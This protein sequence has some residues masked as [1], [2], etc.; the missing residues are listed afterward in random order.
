MFKNT[1]KSDNQTKKLSS[2]ILTKTSLSMLGLVVATTVSAE[3]YIYHTVE[4][5]ENLTSLSKEFNVP[6]K[7]IK[8]RN[9]LQSDVLQ[10]GKNIII[11]IDKANLKQVLLSKQQVAKPQTKVAKVKTNTL[12]KKYR[13]RF[14]DTLSK[15]AKKNNTTL[16][17]LLKINNMK[18]SDTLLAG[19]FILIPTASTTNVTKTQAKVNV[20]AK[21]FKPSPLKE[22]KKGQLVYTVQKGD[23]FQD[24]AKK[25][26]ISAS[27]LQKLNNIDDVNNIMVGQKIIVRD[28]INV[29]AVKGKVIKPKVVQAK[30]T[31]NKVKPVKTV[32]ST[33]KTTPAKKATPKLAKNISFSAKT[34]ELPKVTVKTETTAKS[35]SKPKY[36]TYTVQNGD[37]LAGIA[38]YFGVKKSDLVKFN[39][40]GK[41]DYVKVGSTII[42]AEKK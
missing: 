37:T 13:V 22:N 7:D 16:N 2:K 1:L 15:I 29:N 12:T 36:I 17:N 6:I 24:I 9:N 41:S 19:K 10:L 31:T 28:K 32:V 26:N 8:A 30:I 4:K 35:Q 33:V 14:D 21:Q 40:L 5:G 18:L 42:I 34:T 27:K 39:K 3:T 20:K 38:K 25:M 23:I 11:P